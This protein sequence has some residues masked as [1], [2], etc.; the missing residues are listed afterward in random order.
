MTTE[1]EISGRKVWFS[2][3]TTK[4][5]LDSIGLSE[6]DVLDNIKYISKCFG[7]RYLKLFPLKLRSK[8][9]ERF[10]SIKGV[11]KKIE[12][13]PGFQKFLRQFDKNNIEHHLF[14]ARV[15]AWLL[16]LEF[17]IELEPEIISSNAGE[18]DILAVTACEKVVVECK[19]INI[20]EF[21]DHSKKRKSQ[22]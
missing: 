8:D 16:D 6:N 11:L 5:F 18:P 14:T 2:Y 20:S 7:L 22:I 3:T 17:D 10:H 15:A 19:D 4:D 1:E 12:K 9:I 13:C 21:F